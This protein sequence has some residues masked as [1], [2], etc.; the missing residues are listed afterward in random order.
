MVKHTI[1]LKPMIAIRP[2][3][4]YKKNRGMS[5]MHDMIDWIGGFPFQFASYEV[6]QSYFSARGFD[7]INGKRATSLGCHEL[8][9][10]NV[11]HPGMDQ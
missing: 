10:Q 3:L 5:R 1:K 9:F 7:Q 6:L 4:S 2:L 11:R 8:V